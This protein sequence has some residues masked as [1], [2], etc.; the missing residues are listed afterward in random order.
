[1]SDD[2]TRLSGRMRRLVLFA[3]AILVLVVVN[4]QIVI[5]EGIIESGETLLLRLA[6]RDPRSLLQ[7]DYMVLRYAMADEVARAAREAEL[8]DGVVVVSRG[9]DRQAA[10]VGLYEGRTLAPSQHLLRFRKRGDS[11]R[12]AS[13]AYFFEEG[14]GEIFAGARFGELRVSVAGDAVLVGLR[15]QDGGRLGGAV[16][17]APP[18]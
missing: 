1:M 8:T 9:E 13:D 2:R 12:L 17:A 18:Q 16:R 11:V 6:P 4:T 3:T 5:K 10:F 15:G 7:G 14:Q